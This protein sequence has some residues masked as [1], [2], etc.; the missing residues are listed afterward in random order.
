LSAVQATSRDDE[1]NEK[2]NT[3]TKANNSGILF[4]GIPL[5]IPAEFPG[6][7]MPR[8]QTKSIETGSKFLHKPNLALSIC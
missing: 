1:E 2:H 7:I 5:N 3:I 4:I 6:T 8:R